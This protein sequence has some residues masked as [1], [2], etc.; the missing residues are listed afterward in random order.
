MTAD[1]IHFF[2]G[3]GKRYILPVLLFYALL[4]LLLFLLPGSVCSSLARSYPAIPVF[5]SL[6]YGFSFLL[7]LIFVVNWAAGADLAPCGM[8]PWLRV[9]TVLLL[10]QV[11]FGLFLINGL[12]GTE[13]MKKFATEHASYFALNLDRFTPATYL[14]TT[15]ITPL[16]YLFMR[17][18]ARQAQRSSNTGL[19]L[20]AALIVA[21][22]LAKIADSSIYG[23]AAVAVIIVLLFFLC[24]RKREKD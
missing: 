10:L 16:L 5:I 17:I 4:N 22:I 2:E 7:A 19:S 8:N 12:I 18:R 21:G 20:L 24:G 15:I 9:L 6:C 14:A 23:A 1:Q 13:L 11:W 3:Y